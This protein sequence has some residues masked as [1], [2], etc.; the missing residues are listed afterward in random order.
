MTDCEQ[1]TTVSTADNASVDEC[2]ASG[3]D[4]GRLERELT[5]A[6]AHDRRLSLEN[7]AKL[8][9]VQQRVGSY[10][11]FSD[12]VKAAG[13]KPLDRKDRLSLH[14]GGFPANIN[15]R[16]TMTTSLYHSNNSNSSNTKLGVD[17]G[18][19]KRV[20]A[21]STT[22][23]VS[24]PSTQVELIRMWRTCVDTEA[25]ISLLYRTGVEVFSRLVRADLSS[26]LLE[27]LPGVLLD[28]IQSQQLR[29]RCGLD[30]QE[31][32]EFAVRLLQAMS[33]SKSFRICLQFLSAAERSTCCLLLTTLQHRVQEEAD[34]FSAHGVS[35]GDIRELLLKYDVAS[36]S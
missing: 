5:A 8:R 3:F 28:K 13:M 16:I 29:E 19:C 14:S 6:I 23:S 35:Q 12:M 15:N 2:G 11:E 26:E 34:S 21:L 25:R 9:A 24:T 17:T 27:Q 7:D 32:V 36:D 18:Q 20:I 22:P 33:A 31:S 1:Q 4:F 30:V 10:Q